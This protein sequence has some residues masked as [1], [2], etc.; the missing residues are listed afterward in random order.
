MKRSAEAAAK[1]RVLRELDRLLAQ[2]SAA[3]KTPGS[4]RAG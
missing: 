3:A 2:H 4:R 1:C